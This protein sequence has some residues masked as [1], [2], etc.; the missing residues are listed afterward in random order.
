MNIN[1]KAFVDVL[2]LHV[3]KCLNLIK[4]E[5][6]ARIVTNLDQQLADRDRQMNKT[7]RRIKEN[8]A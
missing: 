4:D 1:V 7:V 3:G 5:E 6:Q 2:T 8:Y